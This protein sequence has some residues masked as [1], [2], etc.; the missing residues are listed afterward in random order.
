MS[1]LT[2]DQFVA[3][4]QA[5]DPKGAGAL[6]DV[7]KQ[8]QG[9]QQYS[10][11]LNHLMREAEKT[12]TLRA[13]L[14]A[15]S[16][17]A[18]EAPQPVAELIGPQALRAVAEQLPELGGKPPAPEPAAAPAAREPQQS[19]RRTATGEEQDQRFAAKMYRV[20]DTLMPV[21]PHILFCGYL[22]IWRLADWK[23][24]EFY[25]S[26]ETVAKALGSQDRSTGKRVMRTLVAAGLVRIKVPGREHRATVYRLAPIDS[27]DR[28][29]VLAAVVSTWMGKNPSRWKQ[30]M[31]GYADPPAPGASEPEA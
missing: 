5:H 10:M 13:A 26:H 2:Y 24:G 4:L 11:L 22:Y 31:G 18:V 15:L 12:P 9:E 3:I 30:E 19:T 6:L 14:D 21:L 7:L 27:V 8:F 29:R 25:V 28:E 17:P 20:I 23:T 1:A 16:A